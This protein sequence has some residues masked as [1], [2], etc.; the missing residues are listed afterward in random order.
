MKYLITIAV[1]SALGLVAD[2]GVDLNA[3]LDERTKLNVDYKDENVAYA[4]ELEKPALADLAAKYEAG[5]GDDWLAL[6]AYAKASDDVELKKLVLRLEYHQ[7]LTS[8]VYD[9]E[10]AETPQD[11]KEAQDGLAEYQAK[12]KAIQ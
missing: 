2:Q 5:V 9:A 8:F 11:V 1:V 4:K 7:E 3:L 12:M 6:I 10:Y